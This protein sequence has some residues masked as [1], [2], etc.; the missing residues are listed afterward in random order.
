MTEDQEALL[1]EAYRRSEKRLE[2]QQALAIAFDTRSLLHAAVTV[3]V[4]AYVVSNI[5]IGASGVYFKGSA[6][7]L[8]AS[9]ICATISAIPTR[10]YTAGSSHSELSDLIDAGYDELVVI[11]G[12]AENND[13][14]IIRND[15]TANLRASFYRI[16]IILFVIGLMISLAGLNA[17]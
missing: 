1:R 3:A 17:S 12:L 16:S 11:K 4:L 6:W 8:T 13:K 2:N 5:N 15:F 10:L 7:F 14:F 9:L